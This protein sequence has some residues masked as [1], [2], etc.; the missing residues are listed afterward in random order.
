MIA[1]PI[2]IGLFVFALLAFL[3]FD[4]PWVT[5]LALS[6]IFTCGLFYG[7]GIS[8]GG[9]REVLSAESSTIYEFVQDIGDGYY[10][11]KENNKLKLFLLPDQKEQLSKIKPKQKFIERGNKLYLYFLPI[12]IPIVK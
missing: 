7:I 12:P 6:I 8:A 1:V 4:R 11:L 2:L 9:P 3:L 10:L 5:W